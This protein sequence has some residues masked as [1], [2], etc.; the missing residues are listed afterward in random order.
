M[1]EKCCCLRRFCTNPWVMGIMAMLELFLGFILLSFPFLLGASAV[2]VGGF[3]LMAVGLMRL[4]Q[5]FRPGSRLW[6]LL[7]G[8]VYLILGWSMVSMTVP[9]LEL[10]T[11]VIGLALFIGGIIRFIV[12]I[13]MRRSAGSPWRFFNAVVSIALGLMVIW[14]WPDSSLWLIGTLIAVEMIFSGW[15]LFFLALSSRSGSC[16]IGRSESHGDRPS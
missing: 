14:G 11:L 10:W 13:A 15:T 9:S 7:A 2:W 1:S 8:I 16:G 4:I 3:V 6:N 12:A 5:V